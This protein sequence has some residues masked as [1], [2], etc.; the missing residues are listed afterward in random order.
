MT[1]AR[2]RELK[3]WWR[4]AVISYRQ[5]GKNSSWHGPDFLEYRQ[6]SYGSLGHYYRDSRINNP[7]QKRARFHCKANFAQLVTTEEVVA[8]RKFIEDVNHLSIAVANASKR[9]Q[10]QCFMCESNKKS[11]YGF[12]YKSI[13]CSARVYVCDDCRVPL[14]WEEV[15]PL[16]WQEVTGSENAQ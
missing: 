9:P 3:H 12:H 2:K 4:F 11:P 7:V 6:L 10:W 8:V 5:Y 1:E 16:F 13:D 14:R 15:I